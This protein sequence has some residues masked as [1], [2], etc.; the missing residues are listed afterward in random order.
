MKNRR[1]VSLVEVMVAMTLFGI[2]I[3]AHTLVTMRYALRNR[4]AA[5]GVNRAAAMSTAVDLF[6]TM[7]FTSLDA[8]DGCATI[9]DQPE[10][11]HQR[12]VTLTQPSG[13]ITRVRIII[14]PTNAELR[15]DTVLVDRARPPVGSLFS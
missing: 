13:S 2:M 12:C 1:G 11:I 5:V 10:Y 8:N 4:I 15:P 6:S 3:T 9:S 14:T 7:P